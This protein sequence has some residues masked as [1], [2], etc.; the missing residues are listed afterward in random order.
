MSDYPKT[1]KISVILPCLN[2]SPT[3]GGVI[4]GIRKDLHA[5]DGSLEILVVDNGSTDDSVQKAVQAGARVLKETRRG[6]G[7]ALAKGF[8]EARGEILVM[9]DADGTYDPSSLKEILRP[10]EDGADLVLGNRFAAPLPRGTISWVRR[11]FGNRLATTLINFLYGT[12]LQDSQTGL[13]AFRKECWQR[14]GL[15][16]EG[17]ELASEMIIRSAQS[18]VAIKEVPIAYRKRQ[19]EASKFRPIRDSLRHA[20]TIFALRFSG[21][22]RS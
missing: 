8:R 17:M 12:R 3:I 16:A 13:R 19:G 14:L 9:M 6:Y 15:R 1:C 20:R 11:H 10:L 21:N 4:R 22:G 7:A 2:E 18:R 5:L